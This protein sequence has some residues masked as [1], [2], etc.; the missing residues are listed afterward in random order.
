MDCSSSRHPSAR[1]PFI[2]TGLW[3]H[4]RPDQAVSTP[5]PTPSP[6]PSQ[7]DVAPSVHSAERLRLGR[8]AAH[9][10]VTEE[11]EN[12][13]GLEN[14]KRQL[15]GVQSWIQICRRHGR[16]PRDEWY[17]IAFQ[18]NPGTGKSTVARLYAKMLFSMGISDSDAIH[19][20]SGKE[21]LTKGPD[22]VREL[23]RT[24]M[25]SDL[26]EVSTAG[27]LVVDDPHHISE[28]SHSE[29]AQQT[30]GCIL[31]AME[32]KTGRI[33]V[34]FIGQHLQMEKFLCGSPQLRERICS[35][36][37]FGDFDRRELLNLLWRRINQGYRGR[38]QVEG[39][40]ESPYMQ[41]VARRLARGRGK[42]GFTN[43]HAV[44]ELV[45]TVARRQAEYLMQQQDSGRDDLDYFFFSRQD[46]LGPGPA[47]IRVQSQ[48]WLAMQQLVGQ[49]SVKASVREVFDLVEE[50]YQRE[51]NNQRRLAIR[52]NRVF[53]G[54]PG[55]GKTTAARFYAQILADLGLVGSGEV[56]VKSLSA[57]ARQS[58]FQGLT[59]AKTLIICVHDSEMLADGDSSALGKVLDTLTQEFSN[60]HEGRCVIA[61]GS[62]TSMG[63]ILPALRK[64]ANVLDHQVVTFENFG[65]EQ[66][67]Q[68]LQMRLQ[69]HEI[70]MTHEAFLK[71]LD[72]LD[73]I[74]MRKDFDN[75]SA[76]DRLLDAANQ[77]FEERRY[78]AQEPPTKAE[79][80]LQVDDLTCGHLGAGS[81]V[82][83]R[84]EMLRS[85]VPEDIVTLLERYNNEMR[86]SWIQGRDPAHRAPRTFVL[87]GACGTGKRTV[88][89]HLGTLY[90]DMG[91]LDTNAL[92]EYSVL[93]F[94][95]SNSSQ[96]SLRT[97]GLL[98]SARGKALFITDAH[99]LGDNELTALVLDE[100]TNLLPKYLHQ[101]VVILAGPPHEID[102][103]VGNRP[104]LASLF[105]EEITFRTPTPHESLRFLDRLLQEES[106]G[107]E[108]PFL[109]NPQSPSYREFTRAI[110]VLSMFP[111]WDNIRDIDT[112]RRW[113][114]SA[115]MQDLPL[116][117]SSIPQL[118]LG[119]EQAMECMVK[120]Y[121]LKR[122]RL[123][124]NHDPKARALP[125]TLSQPRSVDRTPVR[126]PV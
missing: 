104:R 73:S 23:I 94:V 125:R 114:V 26:P 84:N 50:N 43:A 24:M 122:D 80:I 118:H 87:K 10:D 120:L 63:Q 5:P 13:V 70:A 111:C 52:T 32:R 40:P 60:H 88:A 58:E 11:L 39:G 106:I 54:P 123:R 67:K 62:T 103:L 27:V 124:F 102:C 56:T 85:L 30:L 108:R 51:I 98:D 89:H 99:R 6:A 2:L 71:A 68:L 59:G 57:M 69:E 42:D 34:V 83:S 49:E 110:H 126:F 12:L 25:R 33:I 7:I 47:D 82:Y 4:H 55:T 48:A 105:Q 64:Q 20:T 9:R 93:D 14:V 19:E 95:P 31:E 107:G 72:I 8:E 100:L 41:V 21:L 29:R 90:Y 17:N 46:L 113:M 86:A 1:F 121:N 44:R 77:A 16:D 66:L 15:N 96:T 91:I 74:R 37:H 112:L 45:A 115:C 35:T 81:I 78:R 65:R 3:S 116:D 18:G 36:L 101:T 75:A 109:T 92:V 76:V 53:V 79:R 22:G 28:S 38:M 61:V 97:R 117:G 119:E